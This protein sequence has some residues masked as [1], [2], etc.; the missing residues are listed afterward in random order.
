[1]YSLGNFYVEA[2]YD[3]HTNDIKRIN[4]LESDAD[5]HGFMESINLSYLMR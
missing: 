2:F 5:W 4:G 3:V 1:M